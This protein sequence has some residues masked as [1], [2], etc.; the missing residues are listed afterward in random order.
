M[1]LFQSMIPPPF[2]CKRFGTISLTHSPPIGFVMPAELFS[3]IPYLYCMQRYIFYFIETMFII[4]NFVGIITFFWI[5]VI[6]ININHC[7][8]YSGFVRRLLQDF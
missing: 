8:P 4:Y 1:W 6:G 2:F 3:Q 5:F 7:F